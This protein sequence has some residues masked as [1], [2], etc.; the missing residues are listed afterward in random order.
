MVK[1]TM[2]S[3]LAW[4]PLLL[5]LVVVQK[6]MLDIFSFHLLSVELSLLFVVFAGFSMSVLKGGML[7]LIAG[8]FVG[9]L[10]GTVTGLFMFVYFT[11]FCFSTL[12]SNRVY[13][14]QTYFIMVFTMFCA[15]LEGIMLAVINRYVLGAPALY[16]TLQAVLPQVFILG[17]LSP[18]FFKAFRKFEVLV[19]AKT[20]Q[21]N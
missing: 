15:L 11:L 14:Q 19:H 18:F 20:A 13:F 5:L 6:T 21:P 2:I 9:A 17:L 10:T 12:V 8:F 7:T 3:G 16:P 1:V 4:I